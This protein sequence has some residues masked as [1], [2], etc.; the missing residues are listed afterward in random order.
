MD[1]SFHD[2]VWETS[3][4]DPQ[5]PNVDLSFLLS[6]RHFS[7]ALGNGTVAGIPAAGV[8]NGLIAL[9]YFRWIT[10]ILDRVRHNSNISD[11]IVRHASWSHHLLRV[12]ERIAMWTSRMGEWVEPASEPGRLADGTEEEWLALR[13]SQPEL[14]RL[15]LATDRSVQV[16]VGFEPQPS[17]RREEEISAEADQLIS[18]GRNGAAKQVLRAEITK[19]DRVL[20][21]SGMAE[22]EPEPPEAYGEAP[23][24]T[25]Q[26]A[27]LREVLTS[28]LVHYCTKLAELGDIDAA[29]V[30]L[31]RHDFA[32]MFSAEHRD[33]RSAHA[34]LAQA[35]EAAQ[36]DIAA[37]PGDPTVARRHGSSVS[38]RATEEH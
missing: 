25:V 5:W 14:Q 4:I 21:E 1:P 33:T 28:R 29:A 10:E 7:Q 6:P 11:K 16:L 13:P 2:F 36:S 20:R 31:V 23:V 34:L 32:E 38:Q 19:V 8:R 22:P 24:P 27:G 3:S 17:L 18:E 37:V 9:D 30:F 35:R 12:R 26:E 15:D